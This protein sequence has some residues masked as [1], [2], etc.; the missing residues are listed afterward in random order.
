MLR[1]ILRLDYI[2]PVDFDKILDINECHIQPQIGNEILN[3][4]RDK[5]IELKLKPYDAK[6]HIGYLRHLV[7][8]IWS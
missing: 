3:F 5:A 7:L 1:K 6:T 8:Q 4:V 2:S